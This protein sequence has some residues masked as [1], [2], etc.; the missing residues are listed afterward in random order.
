MVTYR[1]MGTIKLPG[2]G[3]PINEGGPSDRFPNAVM[4][5]GA[6]PITVRERTMMSMMNS[7]TDKPEW[8]RKVFE[9]DIVSKWR[10][11]ALGTEDMDV[12]E[13]MLDWVSRYAQSV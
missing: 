2:F 9:D 8:D 4:D 12:T 5:W 10:Q 3:L 6:T 13:K 1:K 7:I 11:E